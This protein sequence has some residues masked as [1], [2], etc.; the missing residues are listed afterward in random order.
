MHLRARYFQIKS[1]SGGQPECYAW[2]FSIFLGVWRQRIFSAW[3]VK[4]IIHTESKGAT[5]IVMLYDV[6][7]WTRHVMDTFSASLFLRDRN[8]P[9]TGGFPSQGPGGC[10]TKVS[11]ALQNNVAKI[12]NARNH[13]YG[14]NFMLKLCT[15]AQNIALGSRTKFQP[16]ILIK[17]M[18]SV[19]H[20]CRENILES[21]RNLSETT[22][23]WC[24][25]NT[26]F[27]TINRVFGVL[28]HR[29]VHVTS[30]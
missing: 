17:C 1:K 23:R 6:S 26:S 10:F 12:H 4:F 9:I 5:V 28:R 22:P 14:E 27:W 11:R 16:E 18:I 8:T 3:V 19:I 15:C 21:S 25:P 20:K 13:I 30:Q 29:G 24:M 2:N 7:S